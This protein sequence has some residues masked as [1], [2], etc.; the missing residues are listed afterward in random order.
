MKKI[1]DELHPQFSER[2]ER[3]KRNRARGV[4]FE[5]QIARRLRAIWP[6]A[7]RSYGQARD[8]NETPD[9][10][11]TPFWIECSKGSTAAIHAKLAQ[12]L[13][14]AATTPHPTLRNQP[15]IVIA[16][17]GGTKPTTVTMTL[18]AF[19]ALIDARTKKEDE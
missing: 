19:L 15:T 14:A 16:H 18:D 2:S 17:H 9:V 3:G 7:A 13:E 11:G 6:R 12:G 5:R 1:I 4:T 10:T 8:G